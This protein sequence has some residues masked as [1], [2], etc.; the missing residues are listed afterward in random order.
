F[1]TD[2][3]FDAEFNLAGLAAS[4]GGDGSEGI[5][6]RGT[7]AH[8]LIGDFI[9]GGKDVNGDG[10]DDLLIAANRADTYRMVDAGASYLVFGDRELSELNLGDLMEDA[11]G[12]GSIG[13]VFQGSKR[14]A[15]TGASVRLTGD[16]NGDGIDDLLVG[17]GNPEAEINAIVY[18]STEQPEPEIELIAFKS[19]DVYLD[20]FDSAEDVDDR[21]WDQY[22]YS[23]TLHSSEG[24]QVTIWGDP[25]VVITIGGVTERFDIG[26]GAGSIKVD[27]KLTISWD[28]F[29]KSPDVFNGQPPLKTFTVMIRGKEEMKI[30]T[31]DGVN[32]VDDLTSITD[33]QLRKFARKL[34]RYAGDANLPLKRR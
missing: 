27:G 30:D 17:V 11:G 24:T 34:R 32:H 4:A 3:G 33:A 18:G 22:E 19:T 20:N 16:I 7:K 23:A 21:N 1:G 5:V 14:E 28:T 25:H 15:Q 26:Y 10:I 8:D 29:E 31:T 6:I 12:D 2:Q 13:V 9:Q